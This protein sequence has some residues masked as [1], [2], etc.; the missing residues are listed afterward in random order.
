MTSAADDLLTRAGKTRFQTMLADPPR[1][2]QNR[3]GKMAPVHKQL[4]RNPTMTQRVTN[5]L[6]V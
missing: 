6:S 3:T 2:F 5:A 1:R 4:A